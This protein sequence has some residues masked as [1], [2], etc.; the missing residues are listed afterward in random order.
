[1][2][3]TIDLNADMGESFGRW[4][5]GDDKALMPQLTSAN[6]ACGFHGGDRNVTRNRGACARARGRYRGAHW[7]AGP[8]GL[9]APTHGRLARRAA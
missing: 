2:A 4:T 8:A 5:L 3:V 1:M 6:I 7:A 9:R